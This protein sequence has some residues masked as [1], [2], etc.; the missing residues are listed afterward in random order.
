MK[1]R[2]PAKERYEWERRLPDITNPWTHW[3]IIGDQRILGDV[4]ADD[5]LGALRLIEANVH[6]HKVINATRVSYDSAGQQDRLDKTL[7]LI[8]QAER[9][10][11]R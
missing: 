10:E 1:P 3:R 8:T 5:L 2:M 7:V 11:S 6:H 4:P 9:G